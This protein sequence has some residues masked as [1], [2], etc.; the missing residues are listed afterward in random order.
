MSQN[1][2]NPKKM[3]YFMVLYSLKKPTN[4]HFADLRFA[5]LSVCLSTETQ[6]SI[7]ET[8]SLVLLQISRKT[9]TIHHH[10]I[11]PLHTYSDPNHVHYLEQHF[12]A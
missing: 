3:F 11:N 2:S 8:P 7:H 9:L 5:Y 4:A 10:Y 12:N 1:D 6:H